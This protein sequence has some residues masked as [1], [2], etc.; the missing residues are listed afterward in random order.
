M[1]SK[2]GLGDA[3]SIGREITMARVET[4]GTVGKLS[5]LRC[6]MTGGAVFGVLFAICWLGAALNIP[7]G[8]HM[9]LAIF[10]PAAVPSALALGAGFC[11]SIL[12]G[13]A[14]GTLSAV[15]YNLFSSS[16]RG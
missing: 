13:A 9:F 6:A 5:I 1:E 12:F 2:G 15:F 16:P 14:V 11:W 4:S 10:S 7:R 8:P 3:L